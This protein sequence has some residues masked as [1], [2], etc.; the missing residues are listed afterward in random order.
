MAQHVMQPFIKTL[1]PLVIYR[2][3]FSRLTPVWSGS[4]KREDLWTLKSIFH[5]LSSQHHSI[6]G[7]LP[8]LTHIREKSPHKRPSFLVPPKTRDITTSTSAVWCMAQLKK[9]KLFQ[10]SLL[11]PDVRCKRITK[12][13]LNTHSNARNTISI[14]LPGSSSPYMQTGAAN[15]LITKIN[16]RPQ[17]GTNTNKLVNS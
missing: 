5:R 17:P 14:Y 11:S 8:V 2:A 10:N 6:E 15:F 16:S 13:Q 3:F 4:Q 1:W 7:K 9:N 12:Q